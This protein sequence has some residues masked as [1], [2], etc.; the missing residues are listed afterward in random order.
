MIK[1]VTTGRF[2][3]KYEVRTSMRDQLGKR[4]FSPRR[5]VDTYQEAKQFE[6][7][8]RLA[9]ASGYTANNA[10][11]PLWKYFEQWYLG[12]VE[13]YLETNSKNNYR[14][15][16]KR[17]RIDLAGRPLKYF[18]GNK[19]AI[20]LYFNELGKKYSS[21]TVTKYRAFL[22]KAFSD[23]EYDGLIRKTPMPSE[24]M[25]RTTGIDKGMFKPVASL[26]LEHANKLR[27]YFYENIDLIHQ[28]YLVLLIMLECGLRPSE[29]K[30]LRFD[31]ID[32]SKHTL[33][34]HNT[35]IEQDNSIKPYTKTRS[36]RHVPVSPQ[37]EKLIVT[38]SE[39]KQK[40]LSVYNINNEH[41]LMFRNELPPTT[42]GDRLLSS[43]TNTNKVFKKALNKV[44]IPDKTSDGLVITPKTLRATHDT[45][46]IQKGVSL[47][48]IA[49]ISGHTIEIIN[50]YYHALLDEVVNEEAEKVKNIWD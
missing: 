47:D 50:K 24:N 10:S 2:N 45:I 38:F 30:A 29:A 21:G 4:H 35:F 43:S 36:D 39:Q 9:F 25:I 34:V 13:P 23:A 37:L 7:E 27:K 11:M 32:R 12:N 46:L 42:R 3:G 41:N 31:D 8:D 16:I 1:K 20:Q 17:L 40:R 14:T 19:T 28:E 15:L 6:S 18:D 48:Y 22:R 33:H 49:R 26:S 5:Y 44:G